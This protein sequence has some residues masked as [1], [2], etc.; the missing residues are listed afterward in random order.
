LKERSLANVKASLERS[1]RQNEGTLLALYLDDWKDAVGS[2]QKEAEEKAKLDELEK[3][4]ASFTESKSIAAKKVMAKMGMDNEEAVA[5]MAFAAWSRGIHELKA[6]REIERE[7]AAIDA[8]LQAYKDQSRSKTAKVMEKMG[9][10]T[11]TSLLQNSVEGWARITKE[12]K[13][14]RDLE[15]TLMGA[16]EKFKMLNSRQKGN[17]S[18]MQTRVNEQVKQTLAT[19]VLGAWQLEAKLT[20][21]DKYYTSKIEGKRKQLG[22]VQSLF[23]S[24]AKQLEEGLAT[25]E[26]ADGE[27]SGR[28]RSSKKAPGSSKHKEGTPKGMSK[29]EGSVSLPSLNS[30]R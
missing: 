8:K 5:C 6:D 13:K 16:E 18:K 29:N 2:E 27:S 3:Q 19:K 24:F 22:S 26:E 11:N 1:A 7:A 30:R 10:S 15:N 4:L 17:A 9:N 28:Q 12:N 23:K 20:R 25:V 14:A 21:V